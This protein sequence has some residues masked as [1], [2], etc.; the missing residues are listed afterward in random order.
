MDMDADED[1]EDVAAT[2]GGG[3]VWTCGGGR[4]TCAAELDID[5]EAEVD[6]EV[7]KELREVLVVLV[8]VLISV[9]GNAVHLL[10]PRVVM[11][12]PRGRFGLVDMSSRVGVVHRAAIPV[13]TSGRD[14]SS[15]CN[16][17]KSTFQRGERSK[18]QG[19]L[20]HQTRAKFIQERSRAFDGGRARGGVVRIDTMRSRIEESRSSN[21]R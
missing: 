17:S 2:A 4:S 19:R 21:L 7:V 20:G 5:I 13:A 18:I 9:L 14:Y 11:K 15:L 12:A 6:V 8:W 1:D 10:P 3:I 16:R